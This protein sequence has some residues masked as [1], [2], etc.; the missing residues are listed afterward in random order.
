MTKLLA[1]F[2]LVA[3]AAEVAAHQTTDT[4]D[5]ERMAGIPAGMG[6]VELI[7]ES[8]GADIPYRVSWDTA[9]SDMPSAAKCNL[10]NPCVFKIE[11]EG[12]GDTATTGQREIFSVDSTNNGDGMYTGGAGKIEG[13]WPDVGQITGVKLSVTNGATES[14]GECPLCIPSDEAWTPAWIKI[15]T[16]D[17]QTGIGNGVYYVTGI[18]GVGN[19]DGDTNSPVVTLSST[20]DDDNVQPKVKK[21]LAQFC[22]RSMDAKMARMSLELASKKKQ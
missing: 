20:S 18:G 2:A 3:V 7:Q 22:E 6:A 1:I 10:M 8:V 5:L 12:D 11:I 14:N 4:T 15:S 9:A 21:C 17:P 16:N 19:P 13:T